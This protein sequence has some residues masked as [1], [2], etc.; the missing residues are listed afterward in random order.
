MYGFF[1]DMTTQ[2]NMIDFM[3]TQ[4]GR[5]GRYHGGGFYEY[6]Q[7]GKSIWPSVVEKF[8]KREL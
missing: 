8:Y 7:T 4:N 6:S 5:G 2:E 3:I 1:G